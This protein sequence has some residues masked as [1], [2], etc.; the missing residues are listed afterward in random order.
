MFYK[1]L[2][3]SPFIGITMSKG[4]FLETIWAK[5]PIPRIKT[6]VDKA[7]IS[8][9]LSSANSKLVLNIGTSFISAK[10]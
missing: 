3:I 8:S 6:L 5:Y 7:E 10:T 1:N 2:L 4:G 9:N